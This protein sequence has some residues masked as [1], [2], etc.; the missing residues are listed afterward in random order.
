[1]NQN[2]IWM[3]K[4][5]EEKSLTFLAIQT[6]FLI[7]MYLCFIISDPWKLTSQVW[8]EYL[9]FVQNKSDIMHPWSSYSTFSTNHMWPQTHHC[10]AHIHLIIEVKQQFSNIFCNIIQVCNILCNN[11]STIFLFIIDMKPTQKWKTF[12]S[13]VLKRLYTLYLKEFSKYLS[14]CIQCF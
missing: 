1:M 5:R 14:L 12:E 9:I 3:K 7:P 13:K 11:R 10:D 6:F 2:K 4:V 8:S